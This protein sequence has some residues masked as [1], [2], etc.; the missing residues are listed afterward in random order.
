M[1]AEVTDFAQP[2]DHAA[3]NLDLVSYGTALESSQLLLLAPV[4]GI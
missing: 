4:G 3:A 2:A 1:L